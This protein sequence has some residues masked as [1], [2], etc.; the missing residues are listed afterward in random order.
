[1]ELGVVDGV[2]LVH[3]VVFHQ[4]SVVL[5][6]FN[7]VFIVGRDVVVNHCGAGIYGAVWSVAVKHDTWIKIYH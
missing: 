5:N 4:K 1:M 2:G 3:R 7:V 6:Q